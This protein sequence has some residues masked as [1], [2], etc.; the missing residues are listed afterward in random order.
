[1]RIH[2]AEVVKWHGSREGV[3]IPKDKEIIVS[4]LVDRQTFVYGGTHRKNKR[5]ATTNRLGAVENG[6]LTQEQLLLAVRLPRGNGGTV[7]VHNN[8]LPGGQVGIED[9]ILDVDSRLWNGLS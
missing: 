7:Q 4:F 5:N 8:G 2:V 6:L 1:M 9:V 3:R